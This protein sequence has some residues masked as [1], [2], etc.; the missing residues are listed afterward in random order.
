MCLAAT[1]NGDRTTALQSA[2]INARVQHRELGNRHREGIEHVVQSGALREPVVHGFHEAAG[3]RKTSGAF[4]DIEPHP[5]S[6]GAGAR[7][8][9]RAISGLMSQR[10]GRPNMPRSSLL[11]GTFVDG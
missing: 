8:S 6:V 10:N 7:G 3:L 5:M 9:H 1:I 4:G 2:Q 11:Q